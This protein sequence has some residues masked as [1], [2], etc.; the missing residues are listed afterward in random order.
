M[1]HI[2]CASDCTLPYQRRLC[3]VAWLSGTAISR[4]HCEGNGAAKRSETKVKRGAVSIWR[5]LLIFCAVCLTIVVLTHV[6]ERLHLFPGMGWGQ[7]TSIGAFIDLV[8][9]ILGCA[10]LLLG[11][12][13]SA[14]TRRKNGQ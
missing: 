13:G 6:A 8:S 5:V 11:F 10:L 4:L 7:P 9:A 12:L 1:F 2:I 3:S 14:F